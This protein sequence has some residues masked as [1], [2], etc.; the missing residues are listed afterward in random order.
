[1]ASLPTHAMA[2]LGLGACFY[3]PGIPK[4]IW[5]I[6][7][8]CSTIPDFDVIGFRF[9]IRYD[10]FWGHRGF[11]HSLVFAAA[12]RLQLSSWD[13][14]AAYRTL[15]DCQC[16]RIFSWQPPVTVCWMR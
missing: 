6:G 2:A 12:L 10:D 15:V 13:F 5:V 14:T 16:G 1:M 7:A 9:G 4:R 8:V 3:K 11:T